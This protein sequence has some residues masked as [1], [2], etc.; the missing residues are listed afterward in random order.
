[1]GLKYLQIG[2]LCCGFGQ[3]PLD[4]LGFE[5]YPALRFVHRV[6]ERR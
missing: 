3:L 5:L 2:P 1:M 4:F 6:I